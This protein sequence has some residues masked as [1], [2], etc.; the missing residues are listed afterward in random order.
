LFPSNN[1]FPTFSAVS[2]VLPQIPE[3]VV[4]ILCPAVDAV[5]TT[6]SFAEAAACFVLA[7]NPNTPCHA[8]P[9]DSFTALGA[10]G[11]VVVSAPPPGAVGE[12]PGGGD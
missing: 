2:L 1:F 10:S 6:E 5:A 11:F 3:L 4:V 7:P 8:F 12:E 9:K